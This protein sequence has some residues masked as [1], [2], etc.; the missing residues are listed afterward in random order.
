MGGLQLACSVL[1]DTD[2]DCWCVSVFFFLSCLPKPNTVVVFGTCTSRTLLSCGKQQDRP[3]NQRCQCR[4][5]IIAPSCA[6]TKNTD[7]IGIWS[8]VCSVMDQHGFRFWQVL[9]HFIQRRHSLVNHGMILSIFD[10]AFYRGRACFL[11][12]MESYKSTIMDGWMKIGV[13]QEWSTAGVA[14]FHSI[15]LEL[16]GSRQVVIPLGCLCQSD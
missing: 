5:A 7:C 6:G 8:A 12:S 13:N 9:V 4:Q 11:F 15:R 1:D 2:D 16:A 10:C 3:K 14:E